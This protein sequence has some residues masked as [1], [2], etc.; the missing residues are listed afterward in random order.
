MRSSVV[1]AIQH[2]KQSDEFMNDFIRSAPNTRGAVI[3]KDYSRRLQWI[4]RDIVT[5]PYFD[6]M[7]RQG[8]KCEIASDA[9][10]VGAI[11]D[12]IPLLNP[13]QREM[14]ESLIEDILK[15]KT[16]EVSIK[17]HIVEPNEMV[18]NK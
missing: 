18:E 17:D 16:I 13:E 5:Y 4:L 2:L 8:I 12:L 9:F 10:S 15:G 6:P 1:Q 14:I 3:F 7:V 11:N